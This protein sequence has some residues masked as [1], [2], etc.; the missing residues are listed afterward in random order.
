MDVIVKPIAER[1]SGPQF[2]FLNTVIQ[3]R[4]KVTVEKIF[5]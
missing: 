1:K 4:I 3:R 2:F 5:K